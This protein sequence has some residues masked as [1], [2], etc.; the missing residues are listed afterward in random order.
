MK[1]NI[2]LLLLLFFSRLLVAQ[3]APFGRTAPTLPGRI[4]CSAYDTG[5]QGVA[6]NFLSN[7]NWTFAS[8]YR[9]DGLANLK[10]NSDTRTSNPWNVGF[11]LTGVW[12]KY[13]V[14]VTS[15]AAFSF[16]FRCGSASGGA[17]HLLVDGTATSSV[18]VRA[19]G[20]W[21]TRQE[22]A[23]LTVPGT[24]NLAVGTHVIEIFVDRSYVDMNQLI[25]S[26][27]GPMVLPVGNYVLPSGSSVTVP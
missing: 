26:A 2:L 17:F 21:N 19:A 20:A 15:A 1:K 10:P 6:Y 18:T 13:T 16:A 14:N 12:V 24:Y 22:W 8:A 27:T 3:E 4:I 7:I 5:G 11:G 23:T 25:A 9:T